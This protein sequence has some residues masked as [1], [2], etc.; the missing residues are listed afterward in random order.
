MVAYTYTG[1]TGPLPAD[2][3]PMAGAGSLLPADPSGAFFCRTG[4]HRLLVRAGLSY[5]REAAIAGATARLEAVLLQYF[6]GVPAAPPGRRFEHVWSRAIGITAN[7]APVWGEIG[8]GLLISAGC[9]AGGPLRETLL[10]T[11]L[12]KKALGERVPDVA[13]LLGTPRLLPPWPIRRLGVALLS[14]ASLRRAA[15]EA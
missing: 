13:G 4:D 12:A 2:A 1:L 11:L 5:E 6:P 15:L 7:G 14:R 3:G 8:P 10:G 9:N